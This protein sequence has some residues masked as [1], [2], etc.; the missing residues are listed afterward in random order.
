MGET[1]K[2]DK[3]MYDK[4]HK[5]K[6]TFSQYLE[7]Q[8]PSSEGSALDAFER[9]LKQENIITRSIYEKGVV[10]D[11]VDAF[12]TTE[13]SRVLFP[14][15]IARQVREAI[16]QDTMLP[17]LVGVNTFIAGDA[18]RTFYVDDQ[19]SDQ[20]KVRVGEYGELPRAKIIGREQAV[21]IY[22]F[23]RAIEASYEVI[24][25]MQI[26][27]I[28]LHVRRIAM[29]VAKDKVEEIIE[30]IRDGDGN[31]NAAP[32]LRMRADLHKDA[33][34]G[35]L[36]S[37]AFLRFL[38]EFEEFPCNTLI[39]SKD[40]F[41]QLVFSHVPELNTVELM[42][43]LAQGTTI[44]V[45][46]SAPQMP[47][48][49]IRLFWHK[50]VGKHELIG[51]NNQYAI[52]QVTEVGSDIAEADKFITRQTNILTISENNGYSK[53]FVEATKRLNINA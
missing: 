21:R 10:A 6:K 2:L 9:A 47:T 17:W 24:R 53:I 22:K 25:R 27:M 30:V 14:E 34:P 12:Y 42:K 52:E 44:G 41:I 48:G 18:Y 46:L 37:E 43:L 39:G 1:I 35:T 45:T 33:T 38:M 23:G 15:Y 50:D 3:F 40:S 36:T 49:S 4:A 31:N 16:V 26:D 8:H 28:A 29:Q 7:E 19:P 32:L 13:E 11:D 5:G 20:K 51:I